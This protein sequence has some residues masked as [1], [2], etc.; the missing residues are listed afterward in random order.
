MRIAGTWNP[1][2]V[3][4]EKRRNAHAALDAALESGYTL[5]DHA[6]IYAQ[7]ACESL[8]GEVLAANPGQREQIIIATK[9]GIRFPNQPEG[10]PHR[11]DFS[12]EHIRWSCEASLERL[13]TDYIDIYQ[14]H[15]PDVLMNPREIADAFSELHA[16]GKV[17]YF[18]VSNFSPSFVSALQAALDFPLI[19]NQVEIHLGRLACFTDG[20]LDQCLERT[21]TPLAWSPLGGGWL[22]TPKAPQTDLNPKQ[23]AL[24]ELMDRLAVDHGVGR[25]EIALAFL[26]KHPSGIVP[27]VG[28]TRPEAIRDAVRADD[29][30]LTRDDW[31]RLYVAARGEGLP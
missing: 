4:A 30:E 16:A 2:E 23:I 25:T 29:L 7:G 8:H 31:Y 14:L 19:V 3:D 24:V 17:R 5:F 1:A 12:G 10:S 27:I 18:G 6:D 20:T 13:Q 26:L 21:I 11:Y 9:C 28:S 15:R 22:G